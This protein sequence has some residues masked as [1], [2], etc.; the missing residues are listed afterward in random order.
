[1]VCCLTS[2]T[3]DSID[4]LKQRNVPI[5]RNSCMNTVNMHLAVWSYCQMNIHVQIMKFT[6]CLNMCNTSIILKMNPNLFTCFTGGHCSE[7]WSLW[8]CFCW[9]KHC[10]QQ[11]HCDNVKKFESLQ[12]D[13]FVL[14]DLILNVQSTIFQFNRDGSSWVEP[15]LS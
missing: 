15:V 9:Q 12:T 1:M 5:N 10:V 2:W 6:C 14:F 13:A 4:L 8:P 3:T 11:R 7:E